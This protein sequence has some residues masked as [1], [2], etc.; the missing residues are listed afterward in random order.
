[1]LFWKLLFKL[2]RYLCLFV[3]PQG[4]GNIP[5]QDQAFLS[6]GRSM[7][8]FLG[9]LTKLSNFPGLRGELFECGEMSNNNTSNLSHGRP[10]FLNP[11]GRGEARVFARSSRFTPLVRS[12]SGFPSCSAWFQNGVPSRK[13]SGFEGGADTPTKPNK[14]RL[15]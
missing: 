11:L 15:D 4:I 14:N 10:P 13:D 9:S 1:M 6:V 8:H 5:I 2:V 3:R 7:I 12:D